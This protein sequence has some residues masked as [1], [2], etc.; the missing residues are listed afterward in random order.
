MQA[1]LCSTL[2]L[3]EILLGLWPHDAEIS[4]S[5]GHLCRNFNF[6]FANNGK[7][8]KFAMWKAIYLC[9]SEFIY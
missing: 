6:R 1:T 4:H 5:V 7:T 8:D 3:A 9:K 2:R